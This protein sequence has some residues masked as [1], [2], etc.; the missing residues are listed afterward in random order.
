MSPHFVFDLL[1][2]GQI[3]SGTAIGIGL[4]LVEPVTLKVFNR[5]SGAG[6]TV[7]VVSKPAAP[8]ELRD[9]V[10]VT[11]KKLPSS[12]PFGWRLT[13]SMP[14][15]LISPVAG[16]LASV[17]QLRIAL[18]AKY[19]KKNGKYVRSRGKRIP[20]IA[21]TGCSKGSWNGRFNATYTTAIP[22][23]P[24]STDSSQ[25]VDVRVPCSR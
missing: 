22:V 14:S 2:A 25:T 23:D 24:S 1:G 10:V 6:V 15:T 5:P 18:P 12:N 8:V 9:I 13:F 21:T 20:Y 4:N 17:Q 11:L 16:V 7:L 19:L 3:G